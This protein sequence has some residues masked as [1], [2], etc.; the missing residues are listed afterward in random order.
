M[1]DQNNVGL[2]ESLEQ[3]PTSDLDAML[4]TE[5]EKEFPAEDTIRL[6]LSVLREREVDSPLVF[7]PQIAKSWDCYQ[8]KTIKDSEQ[9]K[10]P[11]SKTA[12]IFILCGVL[13][14]ALPQKA[15]AESFFDR[16]AAWTES[17][18]ELISQ[19][20]QEG[21]TSKEHVFQTD[22]PGLQE[23]YEVVTELEVTAPV[24]PMWLD[25]R[26]ILEYYDRITTPAYTKIT[27]YFSNGEIEAVYELSIY[28]DNIP[29][30][31]HKNGVDVET[32]ESNGIIHYLFRNINTWSIVWIKDNLECTLSLDC[33]KDDVYRIIDS[34]Y[35]MEE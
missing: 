17:I 7:S 6:I 25:E 20:N 3:L 1:K 22:H 13:L 8:K 16:V 32:H 11:L 5:L 14:F 2:L 26:Y 24:V 28:S 23:L 9:N 29:R 12:A 4:H 33:Q 35:A 15:Q 21:Y 30:E 18:F 31:F 27:A 34:I 19:R 10:W